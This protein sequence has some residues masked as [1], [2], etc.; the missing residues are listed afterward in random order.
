ML[1]ERRIVDA[2]RE[3]HDCRFVSDAGRR[4]AFQRPAQ[5]CGIV[6]DRRHA[7]VLEQVG[8]QIHHRFPVFEHVGHA[9]RGAA[10]VLEDVELGLA[11]PHDV[12][13]DDVGI[14]AAR[15]RLSPTISG[16]K[17]E[18]CRMRS[19]GNAPG[20]QDLLAVI[21]VMQEGVE[22][23]HPLLDADCK[24][25]PFGS[26]ED[27]RDDVEGDEALRGLLGAI[28]GEG[29]AEPAE[30]GLGFLQRALDIGLAEGSDPVMDLRI[31]STDRAV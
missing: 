31:G 7:M 8:K 26:R 14:D 15:R 2:G 3:E 4:D 30:Y 11:H 6:L 17:A 24:P 19:L 18:F 28:D 23:A 10:I 22:G 5:H 13:A 25:A 9:G 27:A 1:E 20:A 16:T 12:D 29:D 21:D